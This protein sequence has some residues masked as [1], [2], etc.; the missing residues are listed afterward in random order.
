MAVAAITSTSKGSATMVKKKKEDRGQDEVTVVDRCFLQNSF[1]PNLD[2]HKFLIR[3]SYSR[4][5]R[6]LPSPCMG[7]HRPP[8]FRVSL[9]L[10]D[11]QDQ[12]PWLP[13]HH[14]PRVQAGH[15]SVQGSCATLSRIESFDLYS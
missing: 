8:W 4:A 15:H 13:G 9:T 5:G 11:P 1:F 3:S 7:T 10:H 2:D 12:D 6:T 14:A